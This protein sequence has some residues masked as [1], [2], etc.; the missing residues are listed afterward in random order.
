MHR[1]QSAPDP[2]YVRE[3]SIL[4]RFSF[5]EITRE[6]VRPAVR[7]DDVARPQLKQ[8]ESSAGLPGSR[9]TLRKSKSSETLRKSKNSELDPPRTASVHVARPQADRLNTTGFHDERHRG[10]SSGAM[11]HVEAFEFEAPPQ[12]AAMRHGISTPTLAPAALRHRRPGSRPSA[13][14]GAML[15][16]LSWPAGA[17]PA[18]A[19]GLLLGKGALPPT[20]AQQMAAQPDAP[21]PMPLKRMSA[22]AADEPDRTESPSV[23]PSVSPSRRTSTVEMSPSVSPSRRTSTVEMD[24][25]G[26]SPSAWKRAK[27][28]TMR[29]SRRYSIF[30]RILRP[31]NRW[32]RTV[33]TTAFLTRLAKRIHLLKKLRAIFATIIVPHRKKLAILRPLKMF[34]SLSYREVYAL[35]GMMKLKLLPRYAKAL[36]AGCA[37]SAFYVVVWG[38]LHFIGG[39]EDGLPQTVGVGESFGGGHLAS[40]LNLGD[41]K[42][43]SKGDGAVAGSHRGQLSVSPGR[44]VMGGGQSPGRE[45]AS[46]DVPLEPF[47]LQAAEPTLLLSLRVSDVDTILHPTE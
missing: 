3:V 20:D 10:H 2:K 27:I 19:T 18:A 6:D 40:P 31:V 41:I 47:D 8:F 14:A 13:M 22:R 11:L 5:G 45:I 24:S 30:D 38:G 37:P 17:A 44:E 15:P 16:S 36:R 21:S 34:A 7:L 33:L 23:S 39:R 28:K 4:S 9:K 1:A 32:Q 35:A 29:P 43:D 25:L 46:N 42:G 12:S 26:S